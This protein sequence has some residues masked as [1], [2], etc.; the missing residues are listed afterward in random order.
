MH[1]RGVLAFPALLLCGAATAQSTLPTVEVR[2]G[3]D[4]TV[5]VSCAKPD[6]VSRDDVQRVL[7]VSDADMSRMLRNRF[8]G[9]VSEACKA[10]V[11]HIVV[12]SDQA[13]KVTW[14]RAE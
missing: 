7:A 2:A 14:K 5:M 9:A 13:G 6:S 10:G 1:A 12:Q 11:P 8:I 4:Q 3:T